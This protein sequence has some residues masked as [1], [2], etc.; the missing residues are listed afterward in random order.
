ML[1]GVVQSRSH[2]WIR[3]ILFTKHKVEDVYITA[4]DG[5]ASL[6][7]AGY[8]AEHITALLGY[9]IHRGVGTRHSGTC[10]T[11]SEGEKKAGLKTRVD[12]GVGAIC[13][14]NLGTEYLQ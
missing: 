9:L 11:E 7:V 5:A 8:E 13:T 14:A 3:D 2:V 6:C 4:G 10:Q 12:R 1:H